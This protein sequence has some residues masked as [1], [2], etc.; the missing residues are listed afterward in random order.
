MFGQI[1]RVRTRRVLL[2]SSFFASR[3]VYLYSLSILLTQ[4]TNDI[5]MISYRRVH[6]QSLSMFP[7]GLWVSFYR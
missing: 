2:P 6:S 5:A 7:K 1:E 4:Q 3:G